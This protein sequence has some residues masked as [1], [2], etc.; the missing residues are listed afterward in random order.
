MGRFTAKCDSL[1]VWILV[2]RPE[3]RRIIIVELSQY[4]L[5]TLREDDKFVLYWGEHSNHP[6]SPSVL[7]VAPTSMQPALATLKQIEH[8]YSLRDELDSG[9]SV[10]CVSEQR[11]QTRRQWRRHS[12]SIPCSADGDEAVLTLRR[13]SRNPLGGLH[14]RE[15]IYDEFNQCSGQSRDRSGPAH[16]L[17]D[18][19]APFSRAPGSRTSRLHRRPLPHAPRN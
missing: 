10:P 12:R 5:E 17:W 1:G 18:R 15:L 6:G 11:G 9:G 4:V 8:E 13:R 7:L 19:F 16:G 2:A 14:K 3:S